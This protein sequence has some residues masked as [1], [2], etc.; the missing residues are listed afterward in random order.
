MIWTGEKEAWEILSALDSK[1]A[2]S[3]ADAVFDPDNSTYKLACLGQEII[4]S[5]TDRDIAGTSVLGRFLIEELGEYS[6]LSI[7]RYLVN[8]KNL[9][10]AGRLVKP[11]DLPGGDFFS[12]G[13]HVLPFEKILRQ[14][15]NDFDGFI[16][17]GRSLGGS[18]AEYGDIS[19][20]LLPFPR[21]P[22]YIILWAGDDEF[23]SK[24]SLL[25]DSSCTS[26]VATDILW[27]TAMITIEM[28]LS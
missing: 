26:H 19:L 3:R 11:S 9:P 17:T 1:D 15:E 10:L 14:F 28:M 8:S 12:K 5:L 21:L 24:A 22:V 20:R 18:Q 4:I 13:T 7:L 16:E 2:E 6:R 27:S 25:F 23:P